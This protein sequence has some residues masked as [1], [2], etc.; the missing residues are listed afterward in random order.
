MRQLPHLWSSD[1]Y[2][3]T[4]RRKQSSSSGLASALRVIG[5]VDVA[6]SAL[7]ALYLLSNSPSKP[8]PDPLEQLQR[9]LTVGFAIAAIVQGVAVLVVMLALAEIL[10]RVIRINEA[11]GKQS[12][13]DDKAQT[14]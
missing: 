13:K 4:T 7:L 2:G 5:F 9:Q 10:E 1:Y 14:N 11:L 3:D 6:S 12:H 8:F